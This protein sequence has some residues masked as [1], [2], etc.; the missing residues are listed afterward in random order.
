MYIFKYHPD[1]TIYYKGNYLAE[2]DAFL[3]KHPSFPLTRGDYFEYG[4]NRAGSDEI[5]AITSEGH[6]LPRNVAKYQ[7]VITAIKNLKV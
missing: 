7:A 3:L 1:D 5:F 2:F 4:L 6:S